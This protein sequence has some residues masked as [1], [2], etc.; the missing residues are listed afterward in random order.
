MKTSKRIMA[1][2]ENVLE[3]HKG[4]E[5]QEFRE[6]VKANGYEMVGPFL[7]FGGENVARGWAG[8]AYMVHQTQEVILR[9]PAS[10]TE[11]IKLTPAME[12]VPEP[13]RE[14]PFP[15][16]TR[17]L[18]PEVDAILDAAAATRITYLYTTR[19]PTIPLSEVME[20][21]TVIQ[22]ESTAD[23]E[24]KCQSGAA[25]DCTGTGFRRILPESML[26][27]SEREAM[28]QCAPCFEASAAAYARKAHHYGEA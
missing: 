3:G 15:Y 9:E 22:D 24:G 2:A 11:G 16:P 4:A 10:I 21:V 5:F 25:L 12:E 17:G 1:L 7:R 23:T 18:I 28:I 8:F 20:V 14:N 27:G 26:P 6:I 13:E 19:T